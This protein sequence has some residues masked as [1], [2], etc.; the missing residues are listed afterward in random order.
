MFWDWDGV[1]DGIGDMNDDGAM[2]DGILALLAEPGPTTE[3]WEDP[4]LIISAVEELLR[5]DSPLQRQTR[6][7]KED[8][9]L[10]ESTYVKDS[11]YCRC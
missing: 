8:F 2:E 7:A 3:V 4:G 5:Y 6:V 11:R 1:L 10:A 9:E